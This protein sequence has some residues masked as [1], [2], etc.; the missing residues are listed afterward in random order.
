[1]TTP[2]EQEIA[3]YAAANPKSGALHERAVKFMPGGDTRNSIFWDP[4]PIYVVDGD[5]TILTDADGN[6]RTDM[7]NNMTTLILGHRPAE[8]TAALA[9]QV[10][11]G[12]SFPAPN[13]AVVRWAELMCERVPSLDKVRFVNTGTEATLNA[14][15]AARAFTGKQKLV[16]CEGAYHGNHDAIQISV[17]PPLDLAGDA[18]SPEAIAAFPGI[19]K[20][21]VDD[22]YITPFNDI[23]SAETVIR[24]H[25][26]ELAAVIVEPVN[27]QCGMVPGTTEFL[28][29]LRRI[30]DELG[31]LLIFD[32]VIAFRIAYGG[33]QDYYGI[34]PD[35]TCFGKVIG[36]GM[37][38]GAFG[39]RDDIMAMWDPSDGG[40]TVQHAGTFNG[41]PMTASAGVAT[42]ESLT[43]DRYKYLETLGES[44]RTK[45]RALFAEL[46]VPMGV[47]G[48]ASLFA[49]QFTSTEVVDYR[50]F[51]TNDKIMMQTMFIGL[52]NEG[53]LMSNRC[54]GN[55][56][57][58][59]T[60]DDVDAFVTAVGNVLKR[61][62]YA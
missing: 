9:E 32:E 29:G 48:I 45:L 18:E 5:G 33:A 3:T 26:D 21:A 55:V 54:A 7:V 27:G 35:L 31:I 6:K 50:T 61:T 20:A 46:E 22:I 30:T 17:T 19:A 4:F 58:V 15:R 24:E 60:E 16:K 12:V 2:L 51:S 1:M 57:L 41:N 56:S 8:V 10:N 14:I 40:S 23:V 13:P 62:G 25:A 43:P 44:M 47:T 39:G 49:L 38:V 53:F 28:E 37:P 11:H 36:G 59:H 34:A 42:L 52:L